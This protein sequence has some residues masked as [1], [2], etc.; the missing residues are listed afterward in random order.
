MAAELVRSAFVSVMEKT[1]SY[2]STRSSRFKQSGQA[3]LAN[4]MTPAFDDFSTDLV[5]LFRKE[6]TSV[7]EYK[8]SVTKRGKLWSRFHVL[9]T[10]GSLCRMWKQLI[11]RLDMNNQAVDDPLLEQSLYQEV[12]QRCVL[13]HFGSSTRDISQAHDKC[14]LTG[15]E[16]NVMRYVSGYVVRSLLKWYEK[17][18]GDIYSQFIMCLGEMAV[19]DVGDDEDEDVL[20]YTR[21]WFELVNRG[22][23]YPTNDLAFQLFIEIEQV[24]R[25]SFRN[26]L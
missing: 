6:I 3:I 9:R 15:D 19:E 13:Q 18:S 1:P 2:E 26:M 22:G 16:L 17:K 14:M 11:M 25:L 12:F 21:K 5:S 23:L 24:C 4:S 7:G 10:K 20:S 8:S